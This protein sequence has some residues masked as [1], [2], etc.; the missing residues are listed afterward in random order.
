MSGRGTVNQ[1]LREKYIVKVNVSTD[2]E[3]KDNESGNCLKSCLII[4]LLIVGL[5]ILVIVS[6]YITDCIPKTVAYEE[7]DNYTVELQAKGH[8]DFPFGSQDGRIVLKNGSK[9]ICKVNFVLSNDG[10]SMDEDNWKVEWKTDKVIVTI[11]GEEQT[12]EIYNLYY[13]GEVEK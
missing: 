8:P 7:H 6:I 2:N 11:V 3:T 13:N 1:D 5:F 10:K 12:D 4:F 9:K